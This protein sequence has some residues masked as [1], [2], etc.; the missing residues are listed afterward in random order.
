MAVPTPRSWM[1]P[2]IFAQSRLGDRIPPTWQVVFLC[3]MEDEERTEIMTKLNTVDED[4][5]DGPQTAMRRLVEIPW[6]MD[7]TPPTSV[8][9]SIMKEEPLIYID[10]QSRIDHTAIIA[11]K[12][13]K[14]ST[15]EATRV[16]IGRANMLLG[17]AAQ[18]ELPVSY[19]RMHP[20]PEEQ[21]IPPN[22]N[23]VL[24]SH[25]SGVRLEPSIPTLISLVY[26]PE[27]ELENL[28]SMIGCPAIIHNWPEGQEPCSRAELFRMFQALKI[29]HP[30]NYEAFALFINEFPK[31][32]ETP[33]FPGG[34]QI[35]RANESN[36]PN[37][38]HTYNS[39]LELTVLQSDK[40]AQCWN[41]AW[42]PESHIPPSLPNGPF[43][44]NPAMWDLN[45]FGGDEIVNPDDIARSLSSSVIFVLEKMT[46]T[47]LRTIQWEIFDRYNSDEMFMWVDVSD[48]LVSPD[49]Q[50]LVAY[51]ESEEFAHHRPPHHFLAVDRQTLSDA[52][53]PL[54]ERDEL[55]AIIVASFEAGDVWFSDDMNHGYGHISTGYGHYRGD[56]EEVESIHINL[57]IS[58]MSW[59]ELCEGS[60]VVYWSAYRKWA[61]EHSEKSFARSFGPEGMKVPKEQP[62][63]SLENYV[64]SIQQGGLQRG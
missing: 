22:M 49:M 55:E 40:V 50:G 12:S 48:R 54:D 39:R 36:F 1:F 33:E 64:L 57:S 35:V 32:D 56:M 47:E 31:F 7:W 51:F 37:A 10:D 16:P 58:N 26:L 52:M 8:C 27:T 46:E 6:L 15:P 19:T 38:P 59:S 14:D 25:L 60:P 24:P 17:V 45:D 41:A 34:Y 28:Q 3:P 4:W 18:G 11:W 23:R 9:F 21:P 30:D 63:F 20:V 62:P 43:K 44:Y 61:E 29:S 5:L 42:Y 53:E 13:S 2:E